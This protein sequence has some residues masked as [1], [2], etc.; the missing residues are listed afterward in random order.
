MSTANATF[1]GGCFWCIEAPFKELKGVESVTSG[2]AGGET[3]IRVIARSVR[4][5]RATPKSS[6]SSTIQTW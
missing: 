6:R 3:P 2:Y 1:G 5:P 4:E